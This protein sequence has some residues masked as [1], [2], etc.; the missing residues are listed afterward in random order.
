M[1]SP[2]ST[3]IEADLARCLRS[4]GH[5][6]VDRIFDAATAHE[7]LQVLAEVE[8]QL[9]LAPVRHRD[10]D[11]LASAHRREGPLAHFDYCY[12][13]GSLN[14]AGLA[15]TAWFEDGEVRA[16]LELGPAHEGAPGIAHGG[17]VA[18]IFDDLLAYAA[19]R[20]HGFVVTADLHVKFLRP[21]P[22]G[23]RLTGTARCATSGGTLIGVVG[24]LA[25]SRGV[26]A[27]AT[28]WYR[29]RDVPRYA[30]PD[31]TTG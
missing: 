17:I 8:R 4:L 1:P 2:A 21:T 6:A 30:T 12:V 3:S 20:E 23:E 7:W 13:S 14:P 16:T 24:E 9:S 31:P 5:L 28:A 29:H 11:E 18:A 25:S 19:A 26:A 15:M 10:A 22:I 27:V